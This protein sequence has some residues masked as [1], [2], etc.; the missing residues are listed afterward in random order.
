MSGVLNPEQI[1]ALIEAAKHGNVPDQAPGVQ[2]RGQRMRTVDFSRPTKFTSDHQRRIS[3]SIDTFCQ[4]AATRMSAE[5][6]FPIEL[7]AINTAQVTWSAAQSQ[8]PPSSLAVTLEVQPIGT[9]MLLT[10]EQSMILTAIECLLGGLPDKPPRERRFSEIDWSLTRRL[11]DGIVGQLSLVWQDLGGLSLQIED[12][13]VHSDASSQV[14]S[15]SEPTFVVMIESRMNKQSTA[16]A[17]LIPWLAIDPVADRI[18]GREIGDDDDGRESSDMGRALSVA[19]V[20]LRAEV[21]ALQMPV[22]EI[23]ALTPGSVIKLG[24][25]ADEGIAL[26]AENV[27]LGRAHPGCNGPRRAVQIRGS[28]EAL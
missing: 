3:R 8:L 28:E 17:L 5:L 4:T 15:V 9:R 10:V 13:D 18:S 22:Q 25:R 2:R 1:A 11:I 26:F 14:A 7:E 12:I 20:T 21:A 27:K 24:A 6:R 19:P 23:L 16:M